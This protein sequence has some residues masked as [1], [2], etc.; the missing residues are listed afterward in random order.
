MF[1][2]STNSLH[3]VASVLNT[4]PPEKDG[5]FAHVS[6]DT[7]TLSDN[8]LFVALKGPNFDG[9]D[10]LQQAF[11]K[12]AIA[13]VVSNEN[14]NIALIQFKVDDTRLALGQLAKAK[15]QAFNGKVVG[16]TGS[17]GK[18][19]VKELTTAILSVNGD[20]LS[21]LG[22]L[23][24]DIGLPL[25]LL[26]LSNNEDF[27][28]I[29]MG[30]NHH[31]E[32]DYLTHIA[33]PDV[34]VITN[35]GEAHLE[36]FGDVAGVAKAKGEIYSGLSS[37]GVA[38]VNA[39]DDYADYWRSEIKNDNLL[40]FGLSE[41]ADV[42]ATNIVQK[43]MS[44]EFDLQVSGKSISVSLPLLGLHNV[45]NALAAAAI[46]HA[47]ECDNVQIKSG[48]E[49][50]HAVKGRLTILKGHNQS[51][52]I[53]DTYNAN[54]NSVKA[55]IDVL[56]EKSGENILVL[57]DLLEMGANASEMMKNLGEYAAQNGIH[58]LLAYGEISEHAVVGFSGNGTFYKNKSELINFL[59]N[60]LNA[61]TN[62]LIKGSR[63]MRME[64]VVQALL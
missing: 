14:K 16:V 8:D 31:G 58:E 28:V 29:E 24:N 41:S 64:E 1:T 59:R 26:R 43:E 12:G 39:D 53:D 13:A 7:R 21:T 63:G 45:R 34:A 61:N 36:G 19:T 9:H 4:T 52:I 32:I 15:R 51:V 55:G 33:L 20:V 62:V 11:D 27:A 17:N 5:F 22:N 46:S 50:S 37:T 48:L 18:T 57:G 25:T 30:A 3:E 10:H 49:N 38:I 40:S 35:A 6:T 47:L 42:R 60:K 2:L 56:K 54:P 44:C 23:N